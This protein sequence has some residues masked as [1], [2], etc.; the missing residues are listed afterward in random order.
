MS[1]AL[2]ML[3]GVLGG[4]LSV[5]LVAVVSVLGVARSLPADLAALSSW[6]SPVESVITDDH[7]NV[8]ATLLLVEPAAW[9]GDEHEELV[10]AF[11]AAAPPTFY[12]SRS[13]RATSLGPALRRAVGGEGPPASALSIELA[14]LLLADEEPGAVRRVREDLVATWLDAEVTVARRA[15]AWL[16]RAP[17]CL[18]QRGLQRAAAECLGRPLEK[19]GP[20]D[21]AAIAVAATWRLDLAG[22]PAQIR[23]RRAQVLDELVIRGQITAVEAAS[24][25]RSPIPAP[26]PTGPE[27]WVELMSLGVRHQLGRGNETRPARIE[28]NLQWGLQEALLER[29]GPDAAWLA[30]SPERN[31]VV[32]VNGDILGRS[33]AGN[34]SVGD[35]VAWA[36]GV[37]RNASASGRLATGTQAAP[38]PRWIERVVLRG[39]ARRDLE[40]VSWVE[41]GD[42]LGGFA[43]HPLL[44]LPAPELMGMDTLAELPLDGT[45]RATRVAG[46][47][48]RLHGDL[49]L[50]WAGAGGS[51]PP[52]LDEF[53]GGVAFSRPE[54]YAWSDESDPPP[55]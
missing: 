44:R 29:L 2:R 8:R 33:S 34:P 22:D 41:A 50:G 9:P 25:A 35:V 28:T 15:I 47:E 24:Y 10:E 4:V 1:P 53:T 38:R 5:A 43:R 27:A 23:L 11:I 46:V 16:D 21:R 51:Q 31:A 18:G 54:R 52:S 13:R 45:T 37:V 48:L 39:D 19:L 55:Q 7:A 36:S 3:V 12:E 20:A 42:P 32:A 30:M 26:R 6:Q 17:L 14:R 40:V 49:V